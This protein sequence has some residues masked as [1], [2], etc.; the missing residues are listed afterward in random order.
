MKR[1]IL[2]NYPYKILSILIATLL[3]WFIYTEHNPQYQADITL[4]LR[5]ENLPP[6]LV[7][8]EAP[9]VV[10]ISLRGESDEVN[11]PDKNKIKAVVDLAG[12][13][14]GTHEVDVQIINNT[15][16]KVLDRS[17]N[18]RITLEELPRIELPVRLRFEGILP[19]GLRLVQGKN[20]FWPTRVSL[21]G[22]EENLARADHVVASIDLT[23]RHKSFREKI[24]LTATDEA[25]DE[26]HDVR[27]YP[28]KI[29]AEVFI[30][31][32]SVKV[33]PVVLRY[34]RGYAGE[35]GTRVEI[36]P[37]VVS[38][39]GDKE[40]L[41]GIS[42]VSTEEFDYSLCNEADFVSLMLVY[43]QNVTASVERVTVSCEPPKEIARSFGVKA[44]VIN[45]CEKC[46]CESCEVTPQGDMI[47][48]SNIEVVTTGPSSEVNSIS[49]SDV[50]AVLDLLGLEPGTNEVKVHASL[51][52]D[53]E[54][55]KISSVKPDK[56]KIKIGRIEE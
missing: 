16:A 34:K 5:Y 2:N 26:L 48:P 13:E 42:S 30:E 50:S 31:R 9:E 8:H 47:L 27:I 51:K 12:L 28:P 46:E 49:I 20:R 32:E 55:V 21:Y 19:L 43:P 25:G 10:R 53:A 15:E 56:V 37:K 11:D 39:V 3:W 17:V 29:E 38:L 36:Y 22:E 1:F 41:S 23:D 35:S 6:S 24:A 52:V 44:K 14:E 45:L 33:A 40:V 4:T 7:V 54:G 18:I